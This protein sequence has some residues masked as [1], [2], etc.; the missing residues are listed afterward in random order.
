MSNLLRS[1]P[2]SLGISSDT[3]CNL[4]GECCPQGTNFGGWGL[5]LTTEDIAR[6]ADLLRRNGR[7]GS[8]QLIPAGYLTEATRK[9]SDNSMNEAPDWKRGYGYQLWLSKHGFRGVGG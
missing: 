8:K 3:L 6:F 4:V 5:Y 1:T 7:H 2:E 9:Q